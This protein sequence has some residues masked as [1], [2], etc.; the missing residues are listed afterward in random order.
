MPSTSVLRRTSIVQTMDIR[1]FDAY[2]CRTYSAHPIANREVEAPKDALKN[3]RPY[4]LM[5]NKYSVLRMV[6]SVLPDGGS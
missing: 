3:K 6:Y 1:M 4:R 5:A 2:G